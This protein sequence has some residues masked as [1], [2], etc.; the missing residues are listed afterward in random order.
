[1]HVV[2]AF[3]PLQGVRYQ[4]TEFGSRTHPT[5]AREL[6]NHKHSSLRVTVERAFSALKSMFCILDNKPFHPYKTQVKLVLVCCI[7]TNWI[8]RRVSLAANLTHLT[9]C[10][11]M[12]ASPKTPMPWHLGG[13]PSAM[14]CGKG[15]VT[16]RIWSCSNF[17]IQFSLFTL[18]WNLCLRDAY[19]IICWTSLRPNL[20]PSQ[21]FIVWFMLFFIICH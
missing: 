9:T 6:F 5:N 7:L 12:R 18:L 14:L 3:Y 16:S 11:I 2:V 17:V 1:M 8:L 13:M 4:L 10:L 19:V 21:V 20:F 15:G